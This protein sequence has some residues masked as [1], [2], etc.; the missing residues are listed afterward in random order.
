MPRSALRGDDH[1]RALRPASSFLSGGTEPQYCDASVAA[2]GKNGK[3]PM[4]K[5]QLT[6]RPGLPR[7]AT[8][9]RPRI[10]QEEWSLQEPTHCKRVQR[11]LAVDRQ[12]RFDSLHYIHMINANAHWNPIGR[13]DSEVRT[14]GACKWLRTLSRCRDASSLTSRSA[15]QC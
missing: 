6:R 10:D 4:Q 7:Q 15:P 8:V 3:G 13:G 2:V 12:L 9:Y 5:I 1:A 14:E 11:P